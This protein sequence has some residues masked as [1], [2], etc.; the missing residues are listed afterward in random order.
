M[1]P[2]YIELFESKR[3]IRVYEKLLSLLESC[4]LCPRGCKVN[5]LRGEK[6][7]CSIGKEAVVSS[8]FAHFGEEKELV[9]RYGS[10]TIFFAGCNLKCIY[11]Q[12][13]QISR[14]SVGRAITPESLSDEFLKLQDKGCENINWVTPTPHLPFLVEA[15]ATA[16]EKGLNLSAAM[17]KA[18]S[19]LEGVGGGHK[20]SE[21]LIKKVPANY[22]VVS[23]STKTL[24]GKDSFL[25]F[26]SFGFPIEMIEEESKKNRN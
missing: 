4:K 22:I 18:A 8:F 5:R 16:V 25:L 26:Q 13:Y 15:F 1:K 23:F 6:G 12:N 9:G 17:K 19:T 3:L 11:C 7:F 20:K 10:G 21:R 2:S 24:S 14:M